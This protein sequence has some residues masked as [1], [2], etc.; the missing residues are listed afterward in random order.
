MLI[1]K[2]LLRMHFF[3]VFC[4]EAVTYLYNITKFANL[5]TIIYFFTKHNKAEELMVDL[6]VLRLKLVY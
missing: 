6:W 5:E 4:S 1:R 2:A 3:I